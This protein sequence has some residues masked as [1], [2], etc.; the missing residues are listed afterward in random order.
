MHVFLGSPFYSSLEKHIDLDS[1]G[2]YMTQP[3]QNLHVP[4]SVDCTVA[5]GPSFPLAHQAMHIAS[6][7]QT[8]LS[9]LAQHELSLSSSFPSAFS[10]HFPE[11]PLPP[12]RSL[13]DVCHPEVQTHPEGAQH[14]E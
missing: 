11:S 1:R 13:G 3:Q 5:H 8:P 2:R 10:S 9:E 6:L 12:L 14:V 4:L 7:T